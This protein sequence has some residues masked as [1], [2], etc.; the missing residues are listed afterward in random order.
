MTGWIVRWRF[1][2]SSKTLYS[3]NNFCNARSYVPGIYTWISLCITQCNKKCPVKHALIPCAVCMQ[4]RS[5]HNYTLS[6]LYWHYWC[7]VSNIEMHAAT[8]CTRPVRC[9]HAATLNMLSVLY[10]HYWRTVSNIEM[11]VWF[12]S[13]R[14]QEPCC[15][16]AG[17]L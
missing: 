15:T 1:G 17:E 2:A 11:E 4:Q 12:C 3:C 7:T 9:L 5:I 10:W 8:L 6:V 13:D 16:V 14:E